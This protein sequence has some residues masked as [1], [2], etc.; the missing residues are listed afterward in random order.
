[1]VKLASS[2]LTGSRLVG[3]GL[4][5]VRARAAA[6]G[7]LF[8]T[9]PEATVFNNE[10]VLKPVPGEAG[11]YY[12][13]FTKDKMGDLKDLSFID[14]TKERRIKKND[15]L[16]SVE[17]AKTMFDFM[18]PAT[19]EIIAVNKKFAEKPSEDVLKELKADP[20]LDDNYL[21]IVKIEEG[22]TKGE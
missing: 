20:E 12:L 15:F 22:E 6:A 19:L 18:S 16:L 17:S 21:M 1:M 5:N 9:L 13:A 11:K 4:G 3:A 7:R 8:G 10:Y 14:F 2:L